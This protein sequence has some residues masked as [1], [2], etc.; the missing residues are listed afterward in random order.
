M[1]A[2][3]GGMDKVARIG[4][5]VVL[6]GLALAGVIGPWGYIGVVPLAT[7]LMGWCPAY[8]LFGIKTC[9]TK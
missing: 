7:G 3:V 6:I 4:A 9:S 8:S 2:N 1:K 5:G